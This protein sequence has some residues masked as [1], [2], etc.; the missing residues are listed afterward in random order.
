MD[1][2]QIG[3]SRVYQWVRDF[4]AQQPDDAEAA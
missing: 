3:R 1:G 4:K 2:P